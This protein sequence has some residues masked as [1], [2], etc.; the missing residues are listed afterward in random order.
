MAHHIALTDEDYTALAAAAAR[1]GTPIE[2]LLHQAIASRFPTPK[3]IGSYRYPTGRPITDDEEEEMERLAQEI[4][5]D[6]PWASEIVIEDRG[7]R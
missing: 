5:S 7:P 6:R 3:Q 4:G 2:D 1:T